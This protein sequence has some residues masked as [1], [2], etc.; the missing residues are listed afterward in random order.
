MGPDM[1]APGPPP[2]R[3]EA[4]FARHRTPSI[5]ELWPW[6]GEVLAAYEPLT[7]DAAI[8]LPTGTGKTLLG[9][10][11]GEEFRQS[12]GRPV[13]YLAGNKQLAQQVERE[14]R[15]LNLPVVRFQGP[16]DSWEARSVRNFNWGR[17]IGVMNYWNYF[18]AWPGVEPAGMLILDDVHLLEGP[19]RDFFTVA[20]GRG[21]LYTELL[22]R[23]SARCPYYSIADDLLNDVD[24]PRPPEM[25]VFPD[26]A[27]LADEVRALLDAQ[28][29]DADDPNCWAWRQIREHLQ[30]CCWLLSR[31][32]VTFTPY[33][34]PSQTIEHFSAPARRLYL[35]DIGMTR[36]RSVLDGA[37]TSRAMTSPFGRWYWRMLS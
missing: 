7:G 16:N 18:N 30:V 12:S 23:I 37:I 3:Y 24:A 22:R 32:A 21:A 1:S 2:N 29:V 11:A 34:P 17:A 26:S 5:P 8:E 35:A 15:E 10:L 14:A 31:R 36:S 33:I 19:L 25:L 4:L 20:I 6:Q 9:L 28:L 27:E 13:A